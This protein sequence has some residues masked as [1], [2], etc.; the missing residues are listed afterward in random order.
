M[1][2]SNRTF[3][4]LPVLTLNHHT[5]ELR[6]G[7]KQASTFFVGL[8]LAHLWGI[9]REPNRQVNK[10]TIHYFSWPYGNT[11]H[12]RKISKQAGRQAFGKK[13]YCTFVGLRLAF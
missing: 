6:E 2:A 13:Q 9:C 12:K 3:N 4:V 1:Q 8:K 7:A 5:I 11:Q 10:E